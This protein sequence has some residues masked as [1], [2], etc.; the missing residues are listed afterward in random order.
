M[1]NVMKSGF[2]LVEL[3]VVVLIIGI[4]SSVA[5]PQYR[6]AVT[7]AK[8]TKVLT[9][10]NALVQAM[11]IAYLEDGQYQR[12]YYSY[13]GTTDSLSAGDFDIDIPRVYMKDGGLLRVSAKG[14]GSTAEVLI[15]DENISRPFYLR[16]YLSEGKVTDVE[17][18]DNCSDYFPT[19]ILSAN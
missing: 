4:L 3:L 18:G 2:T 17:C 14:R 10:A 7:K 9:A 16:Y 11:N 8:G 13:T 15:S 12:N 5:L 1:K 6:K 19:S